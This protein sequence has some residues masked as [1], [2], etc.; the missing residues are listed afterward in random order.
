MYYLS[1]LSTATFARRKGSKDRKKRN[2][3]NVGKA[4]AIGAVGYGG[5]NA[6]SLSSPLYN[7]LSPKEKIIGGI[8]AVGLGALGGAGIAKARNYFKTKNNKK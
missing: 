5:L 1:D 8:G 3:V 6:L 7:H 4:A 2:L